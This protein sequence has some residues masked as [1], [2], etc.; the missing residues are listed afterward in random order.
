MQCKTETAGMDLKEVQFQQI[1]YKK[2]KSLNTGHRINTVTRK[3]NLCQKQYNLLAFKYCYQL[4]IHTLNSINFQ[5]KFVQSGG[6]QVHF[7]L[8]LYEG[9]D[10]WIFAYDCTQESISWPRNRD[11][12]NPTNPLQTHGDVDTNPTRKGEDVRNC[13]N[14]LCTQNNEII[15]GVAQTSSY[16]IYSSSH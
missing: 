8:K 5:D 6:N 12:T 13:D 15:I 1:H 16:T 10:R 3:R 4:E 14:S 11:W 9:M 7:Q 2:K